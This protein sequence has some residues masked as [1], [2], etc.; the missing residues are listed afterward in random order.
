[1]PATGADQAAENAE[2]IQFVE[3]KN[4]INGERNRIEEAKPMLESCNVSGDP[5]TGVPLRIVCSL[6]ILFERI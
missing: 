1:M 4:Q 5:D 6:A 2:I 3:Q